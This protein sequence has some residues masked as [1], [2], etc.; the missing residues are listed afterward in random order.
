MIGGPGS[1]DGLF[2]RDTRYLSQLYLSVYGAR[3]MLLSSRLRDD[4]SAMV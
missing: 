3:Q 1:S 4:N 2:H